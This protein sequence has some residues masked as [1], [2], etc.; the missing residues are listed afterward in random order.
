MIPQKAAQTSCRATRQRDTQAS[1]RIA[2][3]KPELLAISSDTCR[4]DRSAG[5]A[6]SRATSTSGCW[7]RHLYDAH[8]YHQPMPTR[9][10]TFVARREPDSDTTE[11]ALAAFLVLLPTML[12]ALGW[13]M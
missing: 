6:T 4:E 2:Y 1:P 12:A 10:P 9:I 5:G 3:E 8:C 13:L 11:F 7:A